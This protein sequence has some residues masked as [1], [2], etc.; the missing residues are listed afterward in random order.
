M[1]IFDD[2]EA[3]KKIEH[4]EDERKKLWDRLV[5]LEADNKNIRA[6][7]V[8]KTSESQREAVQHSKK[9]LNLRIKLRRD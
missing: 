7:I 8:S 5:K 6:E 2:K 9:Q 1:G 4:L 3:R